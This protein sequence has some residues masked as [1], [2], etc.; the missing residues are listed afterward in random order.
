MACWFSFFMVL[1]LKIIE[2]R[3]DLVDNKVKSLS[4]IV[5]FIERSNCDGSEQKAKFDFI[6]RSSCDLRLRLRTCCEELKSV[7]DEWQ[8]TTEQ[9]ESLSVWSDRFTATLSAVESNATDEKL[10][11]LEVC[12][13][14][15]FT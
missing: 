3:I 15:L 9:L 13:M 8:Q 6:K 7:D 11:T 1:C 10:K 12:F 2:E 5:D 4:K 14:L